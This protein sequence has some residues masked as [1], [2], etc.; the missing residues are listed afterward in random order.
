[1]D[2][3]VSEINRRFS[4]ESQSV[5]KGICVLAPVSPDFLNFEMIRPL[6]EKYKAN[7]EDLQLELRQ[8][9]RMMDHRIED[10]TVLDFPKETVLLDFCAFIGQYK[11]AFYETENLVTIAC[12]MS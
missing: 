5:L 11:D 8:L 12:T 2:K 9:K 10:G 6:A 1:M 4:S 3:A 7:V